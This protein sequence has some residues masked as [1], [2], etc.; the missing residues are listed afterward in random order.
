MYLREMQSF[1]SVGL[2]FAAAGTWLWHISHLIIMS[3]SVKQLKHC[4]NGSKNKLSK[5]RINRQ[6]MLC[7]CTTSLMAKHCCVANAW[8]CNIDQTQ[9][10]SLHEAVHC[11]SLDAMAVLKCKMLQKMLQKQY[12]KQ[13]QATVRLHCQDCITLESNKWHSYLEVGEAVAEAYGL[14]LG[15]AHSWRAVAGR[16]WLWP[17]RSCRG[18]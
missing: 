1:T 5:A 6:V 8:L 13:C 3:M 2:G 4:T 17:G 16:V 10:T 14:C 9:V 18:A 7:T 15:A 11:A 12:V